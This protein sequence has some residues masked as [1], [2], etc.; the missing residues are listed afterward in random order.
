MVI[1]LPNQAFAVIAPL[2]GAVAHI[3]KFA[4]YR[5]KEINIARQDGNIGAVLL[6]SIQFAYAVRDNF[7]T[8]LN[9]LRLVLL[10]G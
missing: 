3:V 5:I 9:Q 1:G 7:D 2:G 6:N 8:I 4:V 10:V